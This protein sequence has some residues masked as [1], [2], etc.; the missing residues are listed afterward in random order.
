MPFGHRGKARVWWAPA[1]AL[2]ALSIALVSH[3]HIHRQGPSEASRRFHNEQPHAGQVWML[4][5][6]LARAQLP[7]ATALC[8]LT[9]S[10]APAPGAGC[11]PLARGSRAWSIDRVRGLPHPRVSPAWGTCT[12]DG[13]LPSNWTASTTVSCRTGCPGLSATSVS[14][15]RSSSAHGP[16]ASDSTQAFAH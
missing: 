13:S 14:P 16:G 1:Q 4:Q 7:R 3:V 6:L 10:G 11:P 8:A 15:P 12:C 5:F 9:A 2:G